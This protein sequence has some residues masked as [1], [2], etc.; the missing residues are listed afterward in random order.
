MD[1]NYGTRILDLL[2]QL[3]LKMSIPGDSAYMFRSRALAIFVHP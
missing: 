3:P 1:A 2:V